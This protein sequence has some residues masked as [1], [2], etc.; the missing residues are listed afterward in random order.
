LSRCPN[1]CGAEAE[2]HQYQEGTAH[3]IVPSELK[4]ASVAEG[5]REEIGEAL[6]DIEEG[7]RSI[8]CNPQPQEAAV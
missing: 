6:S 1:P 4:S 3:T 8:G 5:I 7:L 2:Q